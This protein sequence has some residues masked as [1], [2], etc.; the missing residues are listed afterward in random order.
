M[1]IDCQIFFMTRGGMVVT[2]MLDRLYCFD[3]DVTGNTVT[4]QCPFIAPAKEL[5]ERIKS[6][7]VTDETDPIR[8]KYIKDWRAIAQKQLEGWMSEHGDSCLSGIAEEQDDEKSLGLII[9]KRLSL[10]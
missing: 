5:L 4:Y 10:P 9:F 3:P 2:K 8:I 1:G 6:A 7:P